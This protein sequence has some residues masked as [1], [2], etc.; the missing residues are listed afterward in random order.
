MDPW[1]EINSWILHI[2][3]NLVNLQG[4]DQLDWADQNSSVRPAEYDS[5]RGPISSHLQLLH[6][7]F[8]PHVSG[9]AI[10]LEEGLLGGGDGELPIG[11]AASDL[12]K[13][14]PHEDEHCPATE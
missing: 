2:L 10:L 12:C 8:L 14:L 3:P 1:S 9:A 5:S 13:L 7:G 11:S 6:P 4:D